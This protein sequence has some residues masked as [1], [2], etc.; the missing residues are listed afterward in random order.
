MGAS[1]LKKNFKK[2][3][4]NQWRFHENSHLSPAST[5]RYS[6]KSAIFAEHSLFNFRVNGPVELIQVILIKIASA[7][8][9]YK[10]EIV[11]RRRLP[12]V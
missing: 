5:A 11:T 3:L 6:K 1:K 4:M 12:M 7:Y 8:C 10:K 2:I 9:A